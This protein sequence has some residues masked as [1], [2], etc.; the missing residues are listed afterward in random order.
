V[1]GYT[2][3]V[4]ALVLFARDD[5]LRQHGVHRELGHPAPE[6]GELA[7]VVECAEGIQQLQRAHERLAGR[8]VHEL[9]AD[10]VVDAERLEEEHDR[11]EVC[12]LD[13]RH[14]VLLELV[15]ERPLG[16][17][18]EGF[19]GTHAPCAPCSLVCRGSGALRHGSGHV[20]RRS[21][22]CSTHRNDRERSHA[23]TRV[24]RV[25]LDKARVND[26]YDAIDGDRRLRN[27]CGQHHLACAI[28]GRLEDLGLEIRGQVRVDRADDQLWDLVPECSRRLRQVLL[29]GLDLLLTLAAPTSETARRR[30]VTTCS[31]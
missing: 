30:D 7:A 19:A 15:R 25:L 16:V 18:A 1:V 17:Q 9:E 6:L 8:R 4:G 23:G 29:R 28:R 14:R 3:L 5:R 13:L 22:G 21:K 27:V 31:P 12:P 24:E 2:N 20:S 11:A 10:E 26:E